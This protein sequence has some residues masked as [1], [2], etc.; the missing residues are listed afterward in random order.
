MRRE[1]LEKQWYL[2]EE[3]AHIILDKLL[4]LLTD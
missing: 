3:A 2:E 4:E 1:L